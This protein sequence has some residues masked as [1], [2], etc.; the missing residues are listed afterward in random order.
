M[1][2]L[3]QI[4]SHRTTIECRQGFT[5]IRYHHTDVV[6]FNDE[7]IILNSGGWQTF[8]TKT[9][10]NQ[11]SNQFNLGFT[12]RQ[13]NFEWFV[14]YNGNSVDFQDSIAIERNSI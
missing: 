2:Q 5:V 8:T 7:E 9:R 4:G 13:K 10:M 11:A 1:S 3:Q 6:K 14:D 12:V